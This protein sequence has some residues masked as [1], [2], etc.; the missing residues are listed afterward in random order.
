MRAFFVTLFGSL[1]S[2]WGL[3]LIAA[4]DASMI[5]FLPL[6]VDIAV[7]ILT[8]RSR[9]FFWLY[10]MLATAGTLC[11]A[12]ITYGIGRRLGEAGLERFIPKNRLA[13]VRSRVEEKG[14]VA[15][16][17]LNLIPPPFPFT[18]LRPRGRGA[19]GRRAVVFH[20]TRTH[21]ASAVWG[22]GG[23][24]IFLRPSNHSMVEVRHRGVHRYRLI[25]DYRDRQR[26]YCHTTAPQ[27]AGSR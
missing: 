13:G 20:H 19:E 16:A 4:L 15:L 24:G 9:Q 23:S 14:A 2:W 8:S 18:G 3:W 12:A 5:F 21:A 25:R 10:P 11:G 22:R 26:R 17:A 27:I 7:V 6:A 1:L